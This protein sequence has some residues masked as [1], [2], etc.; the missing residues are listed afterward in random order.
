MSRVK[1]ALLLLFTTS[2]AEEQDGKIACNSITPKTVVLRVTKG[3][4]DYID[5]YGILASFGTDVGGKPGNPIT[6]AAAKPP[7]ACSPVEKVEGGSIVAHRG[8]CTFLQKDIE[9]QGAGGE[10]LIVV[11]TD[12][13]VFTP[14]CSDDEPITAKVTLPL[15]AVIMV[16]N[17][18]GWKI[19]EAAAEHGT[20]DVFA[21]VNPRFDGSL[22]LMWLVA[23]ATVAGGAFWGAYDT[24]QLIRRSTDTQENC[25]M[26]PAEDF[27]DVV[28][29]NETAAALFVVVASTMLLLLFVFM[30]KY[31]DYLIL[32]HPE[33][34]SS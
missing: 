18:T 21:P 20:V 34:L 22:L 25:E 13:D 5:Y 19:L 3:T 1:F 4:S 12:E 11:N 10:Q 29:I 17:S 15:P 27:L 7:L 23:V 32:V 30:S 16:S 31:T 8:N 24:K 9:V 6:L 14:S 2:L 28:H 26:A 33:A